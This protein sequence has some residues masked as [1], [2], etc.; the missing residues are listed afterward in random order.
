MG[1]KKNTA[2]AKAPIDISEPPKKARTSYIIFTMEKRPEVVKEN[3]GMKVTQVMKHLG[4]L[5]RE[6]DDREKAKYAK[7]AEEEKVQYQAN[8]EAFVAAGGDMKAK[9]KKA[10]RSTKETASKQE[11][12][13]S[14]SE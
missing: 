5:W 2:A 4:S 9:P 13:E 1:P 8:V 11:E 14:G 12:E 7:M 10:S 6:L 3:P